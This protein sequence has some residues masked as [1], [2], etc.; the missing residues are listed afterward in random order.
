MMKNDNLREKIN[1]LK[2]SSDLI[3]QIDLINDLINQ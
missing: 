3:N 1:K 2:G